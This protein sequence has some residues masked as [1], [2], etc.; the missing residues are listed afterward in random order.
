MAKAKVKKAAAKPAAKSSPKQVQQKLIAYALTF[1]ETRVDHPW[2]DE[3]VKV[4]DK[5]FAA[6]GGDP[7][8]AKEMS[9]SVKLPVSAEMAL[10]LSWVEPTGYGLGKSGWVTARIKAG[11]AA[12]IETMKG[13]IAQ[14]WRACA[15]KTLIKK[16]DGG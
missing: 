12:D 9:M 3:V 6:F 1:P 14:S 4:K 8:G 16:F 11:E 13:W 10:T 2:G 7:A 5:M 15:P